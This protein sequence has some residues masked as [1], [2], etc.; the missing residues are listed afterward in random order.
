MNYSKHKNHIPDFR[1]TRS[2]SER[3]EER[4]K[5]GK[6]DECNVGVTAQCYVMGYREAIHSRCPL[7]G[8]DFP[9]CRKASQITRTSR[10]S[11]LVP[12]QHATSVG[13][14]GER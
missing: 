12:P 3:K 9:L 10:G 6:G 11:S 14:V 5:R 4:K 8:F 13:R 7:V 1:K 2:E